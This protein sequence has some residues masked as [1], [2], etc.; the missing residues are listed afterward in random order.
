MRE[1]FHQFKKNN[2][3]IKI[4]RPFGKK[5]PCQKKTKLKRPSQKKT[6][7][8]KDDDIKKLPLFFSK[9]GFFQKFFLKE[10]DLRYIWQN[11][12]EAKI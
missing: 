11:S 10:I 3:K 5:R 4:K 2:K 12:C 6:M 9:T 1:K 7:S 8:K